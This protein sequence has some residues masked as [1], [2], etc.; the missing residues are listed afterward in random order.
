MGDHLQTE[1]V[2]PIFILS[3]ILVKWW[4]GFTV[5]EWSDPS[6]KHSI[7]F[8][9]GLPQPAYASVRDMSVQTVHRTGK[10]STLHS[11]TAFRSS[12]DDIDDI[13]AVHQPISIRPEVDT[14]KNIIQKTNWAHFKTQCLTARVIS[15]L[16]ATLFFFSSACIYQQNKLMFKGVILLFRPSI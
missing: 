4:S 10:Q 14:K 3:Q 7:R 6:S 8:S 2:M 13:L 15:P 11:P 9:V 16:Y 1:A 5:S 12:P